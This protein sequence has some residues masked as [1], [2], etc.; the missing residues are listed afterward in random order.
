MTERPEDIER[1]LKGLEQIGQVTGALRAIASGQSSAARG[2]MAAISAHAQTVTEALARASAMAGGTARAEAGPGLLLVVG[3]AQGFS[4]AYPTRI[5]EA[6]QAARAPG[7]GFEG[8][9][10][11]VLGNRTLAAFEEAKQAVLWSEDLPQRPE[12]VPALASHIAD[13][14]LALAQDHPGPIRAVTGSALPGHP[15]EVTTI[16]PPEVSGTKGPVPLMTLTPE[17]LLEGLLHEALFAAVTARLVIGLAAEAQ[18][19]TEAMARAQNNLKTR[20]AEVQAEW[21]QARQ[22][23]MTTEMIELASARPQA[24]AG[25]ASPAGTQ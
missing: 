8:A 24:E 18:A 22:E 20:R 9:G 13:A 17:A 5:A 3:A 14:L 4:G 1:R 15:P 16:F 19:R 12:A 10:L 21:Q 11:V 25:E 7:S 23:Q 6:A 2:A